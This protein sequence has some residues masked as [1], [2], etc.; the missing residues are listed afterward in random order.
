MLTPWESGEA[1]EW[2]EKTWI[3]TLAQLLASCVSLISVFSYGKRE[4]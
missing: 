3:L 4:G 2:R 1:V